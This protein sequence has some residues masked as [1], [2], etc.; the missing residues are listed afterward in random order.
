MGRRVHLLCD[1][2]TS[3][4]TF[5]KN[6]LSRQEVS[7]TRTQSFNVEQ[8]EGVRPGAAGL[9]NLGNTCFMNSSVQCLAHTITL[10]RVFLSGAFEEDINR[11]NPLGNKGE[12]AE[13]FGDLMRKLYSVLHH[14]SDS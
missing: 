3:G 10:M 6:R 11:D 7:F 4:R 1:R 13:G 8:G 5:L 12:L 14:R 2:A 9:G